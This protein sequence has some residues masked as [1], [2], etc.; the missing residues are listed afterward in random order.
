M[1]IKNRNTVTGSSYS[2]SGLGMIEWFCLIVLPIM[3]GWVI[4]MMLGFTTELVLWLRLVITISIWFVL[5]GLVWLF[6]W[7]ASENEILK[8]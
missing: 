5:M 4:F 1:I 6:S 8:Y 2:E 3:I 7:Y